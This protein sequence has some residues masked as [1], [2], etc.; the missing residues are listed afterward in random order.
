MAEDSLN[1][2]VEQLKTYYSRRAHEYENMYYRPNGHRQMELFRLVQECR[3]LFAGRRVLEVACGTGFWTK[4]IEDMA[5]SIVAVDAS[6]DM[7]ELAREKNLSPD[8]IELRAGDAYDLS[9][10]PGE[11]DG[12]MAH[13]WISHVPKSRLDGFLRGFH[14][15]LL[16]GARVMMMDN[17]RVPGLGGELAR[18]DGIEDDFRIRELSD[19]T[20]HYVIKNYYEADGLREVFGPY[21]QDLRVEVWDCYWWVSY[22]TREA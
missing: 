4:A 7:L 5:K 3:T 2:H 13:F 14:G 11:F 1:K 22:F 19:G 16:P 8:K 12:G 17:V 6:K 18:I 20:R 10:V 21:A 9:D 15:R